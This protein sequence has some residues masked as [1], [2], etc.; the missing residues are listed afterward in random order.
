MYKLKII[1]QVDWD[2]NNQFYFMPRF[3]RD[4][5]ELE[6]EILPMAE[7]LS[8]LLHSFVPVVEEMMLLEVK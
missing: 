8:Y 7:V 1:F 2:L 6:K 5:S 4:L 3:V